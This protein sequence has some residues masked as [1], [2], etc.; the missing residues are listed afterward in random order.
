MNQLRPSVET[1]F[2]TATG[3]VLLGAAAYEERVMQVGPLAV[4]SLP[5]ILHAD[6]FSYHRRDFV[7]GFKNR[8]F[9]REECLDMGHWLLQLLRQ[10]DGAVERPSEKDIERFY[11][12]GLGPSKAQLRRAS[13]FGSVRDFQTALGVAPR[14]TAYTR[15]STDD[16]IR[17]GARVA[18]QSDDPV[19]TAVFED[20]YTK[21]TGPSTVLIRR[22]MGGLRRFYEHLGKPNIHEWDRSDYVS[23]GVDVMHANEGRFHWGMPIYLAKQQRGPGT[24][25]ITTK[26]GKMSAFIGEI[27]QAYTEI[28]ESHQATRAQKL[29]EYRHDISTGALP[30]ELDNVDDEAFLVH[31]AAYQLCK[32]LLPR[33]TAVDVVSFSRVKPDEL[34]DVLNKKKFSQ[35]TILRYAMEHAIDDILWPIQ[36]DT[37]L[38]VPQEAIENAIE[39]SRTRQQRAR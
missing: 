27:E 22:R 25:A 29:A 38:R 1:F 30:P 35:D 21:H 33:T 11:H 4:R 18:K 37:A 23:W 5:E 24:K 12:L 31:A 14:W 36:P 26:F 19:E 7:P 28:V 6:E 17:Y 13:L 34:T 8:S 16:I 10:T 9:T 3:E 15:W 32:A 2:D 20:R 39:K